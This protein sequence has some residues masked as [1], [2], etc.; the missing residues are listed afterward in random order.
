MGSLCRKNTIF[1]LE[2]VIGIMCHD[3][4]GYVKFKGKLNCGLKNDIKICTLMDCFCRK[5][6]MFE[7]KTYIGVM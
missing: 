7:P 5:Y 6:I 2:N 1:Q 4:E 3:T